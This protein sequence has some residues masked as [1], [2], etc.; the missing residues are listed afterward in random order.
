[1]VGGLLTAFYTKFGITERNY[2]ERCST[3]VHFNVEPLEWSHIAA[4]CL[5]YQT[6]ETLLF[7][8]VG[9]DRENN[10]FCV[11]WSHCNLSYQVV[12]N[13][14]NNGV[15]ALRRWQKYSALNLLPILDLG[16][17]EFRHLEG[18]CDVKRITTWIALLAQIFSYVRSTP[19]Q[20]V[21][22]ELINMNTVSNYYDWLHRVFGRYTEYV[23]YPDY[24]KDLA[25]G[26]VESK[27]QLSDERAPPDTGIAELHR[28]LAEMREGVVIANNTITVAA[29]RV[30][31]RPV[32]RVVTTFTANNI[33]IFNNPYEETT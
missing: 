4:L 28:M 10:I 3:H 6:V 16:T 21:K 20:A 13:L 2:S 30:T 11:P 1:L 17:V 15:G 14:E 25:Q 26:V 9:N 18:T 5:V 8:Y 23:Q 22:D 19:L 7:K 24:E 27:L 12:T 33:G 31:I 32:P 29:P